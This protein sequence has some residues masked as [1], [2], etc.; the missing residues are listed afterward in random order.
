MK[1]EYRLSVIPLG[2]YVKMYGE[3]LDA[4]ISENQ[5]ERSFQHQSV[6]KRIPIVAAGPAFNI[7]FAVA[8]IAFVQVSG[9]PVEQ[10]VHIGRVLEDSAAAEAGL[11]SDDKVISLNG[12]NIK[13]IRELRQQIVGKR[14]K[15]TSH[16]CL[17]GRTG[18]PPSH[19][20]T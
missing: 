6:W 18:A 17:S 20:T 4:E 7:I 1:T 15:N 8:L 3:D 11:Q 5:R 14:G 10:S 9:Y 16:A 19:N 13:R 12:Q 2:G